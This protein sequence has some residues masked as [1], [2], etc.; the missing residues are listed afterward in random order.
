MGS[1]GQLFA[2]GG[3]ENLRILR[4][5]LDQAGNI[6]AGGG[7]TASRVGLGDYFIQFSTAFAATPTVTA[8]CQIADTNGICVATP[9]NVNTQGVSLFVFNASNNFT[10]ARIYFTVIGPR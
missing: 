5:N 6:D 2:P 9:I 10:D 8:N 4:G 1:T 3:A 7:F